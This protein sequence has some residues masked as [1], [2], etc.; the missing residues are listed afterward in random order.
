MLAQMVK[1]IKQNLKVAQDRQKSYANKKRTTKEY[2]VGEHVFLRIKPKKSTLIIGLYAKIPPRYV[3]PFE[4]LTRV[5]PI[6]YQLALP[7]HTKT[8]DVFHVSSLKYIYITDKSHI[9]DWNNIHVEQEG[10]FHKE[11]LCILVRREVKLQ[12]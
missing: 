5:G 10:Y 1:K 4:V 3:G 2:N 12:K 11:P 6:A 8:Y 9:V 7:P